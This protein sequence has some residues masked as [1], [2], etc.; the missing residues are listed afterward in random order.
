MCGDADAGVIEPPSGLERTDYV[1]S[2]RTISL[3]WQDNSSSETQFVVEKS[4]DGGA[5][6]ATF[7]TVGTGTT[8]FSGTLPTDDVFYYFRVKASDGVDSSAPSN[9]I[10]FT[11]TDP[12]TGDF[13]GDGMPDGF[14]LAHGL[15]PY[16]DDSYEDADGDRYPNIFEY[17][18][19]TDVDD[20]G[21]FPVADYIADGSVSPHDNV[22]STIQA[23]LN[24]VA[25]DHEII[26]VNPGSYSGSGNINL[27]VSGSFPVLLLSGSGAR[28]TSISGG[29]TARILTTSNDAVIDGFTFLDGAEE[30]GGAILAGGGHLLVI[31]CVFSGNHA[32]QNGGAIRQEGG[33]V[34]VLHSTFLENAAEMEGSALYV[35][36]GAAVVAK[37]ILWDSGTAA[38]IALSGSGASVE[39]SESVVHGGYTGTGNTSSDPLLRFDGHLFPLSP[40]IDSGGELIT[41]LFDM[42]G[43]LR[44]AGSTSDMGADEWVDTDSDSLPDWWEMAEF[45][46][47]GNNG[48]G[49]PDGDGLTN[50]QEYEGG[51]SPANY[52]SQ[53][54]EAITPTMQIVGGNNQFG[55]SGTF[56]ELQLVVLV[57]NGTTPLANAP[58]NYVVNGTNTGFVSQTNSG[59]NLYASQ[60][61]RTGSTGQTAMYFQFSPNDGTRTSVQATTNGTSVNFWEHAFT[62]PQSGLGLWLNANEGITKDGAGKVS[63]WADQSGNSRS[64][65]QATSGNQPQYAADVLNGNPAIRFNG[66]NQYM[67]I[68]NMDIASALPFTMFTVTKGATNPAYAFDSAPSQANVFRFN[69]SGK[70][71]FW[72]QNPAIPVTW[73]AAGSATMIL[74][75]KGTGNARNLSIFV[76]GS[77]QGSTQ[78]GGTAAVVFKSPQIGRVNTSG[79]Y[80]SGDIS[81]I[82]YYNRTL[83]D[84]ERSKTEAYLYWKFGLGIQPRVS[85]PSFAAPEALYSGT[86]N[87]ALSSDPGSTIYYT[88]DGSVPTASSTVYTGPIA[89]TQT[90]TIRAIASKAYYQNSSESSRTY[91][92]DNDTSQVPR[93]GLKMWLRAD[94]GIEMGSMREMTKWRDMSGNGAH[95]IQADP[96]ACPRLRTEVF[97]GKPVVNFDGTNSYMTFSSTLNDAD[98]LPLTLIVVARSGTNPGGLF[99]S[100]PTQANVFRFLSNKIEFWN[101]SPNVNVSFPLS[102][103]I[104]TVEGSKNGS[105]QRLLSVRVNGVVQDGGAKTGGTAGVVFMNG[106]LGRYNNPSITDHRY[107]GGDVAEILF[108]ERS[109]TSTERGNIESYLTSRYGI[110]GNSDTDGDSL[111]D[112]WETTYFGGISATPG[113]DADN[114]GLT[115]LEEFVLGTSPIDSDTDGDG[116]TDKFEGDFRLDPLDDDS[117]EDPDGDGLMNADE[118]AAGTNPGA[119]DSDGDGMPDR[120]EVDNGLNPWSDDSLDDFDGDRVPNLWECKKGTVASADTSAPLWDYIVDPA[121]AGDSASDNIVSSI[122]AAIDAAPALGAG[123]VGYSTVYVKS[124]VYTD[125]LNI[126][127][128]KVIAIF[129]ELGGDL[130][131][132]ASSD[133]TKSS[134]NFF[135]IGAVDGLLLTRPE[136]LTESGVNTS[137]GV[138]VSA[139]GKRAKISNCVITGQR[140]DYGAVRN[141]SGTLL[142]EHCTLVGNYRYGGGGSI[143]YAAAQQELDVSNSIFWNPNEAGTTEFATSGTVNANYNIIRGGQFGGIDQNPKLRS[144]WTLTALSPA[145]NAGGMSG[146]VQHD[147]HGEARPSGTARD[148]GVDEFVDE[149]EDGMPDHWEM[150]WFSDLAQDANDDFDGDGLK[151]YY[152]YL[153]NFN[154][155]EVDTNHNGVGDYY[156]AL[157]MTS[158]EVY[159][160][161]WASDSDGDGVNAGWEEYF[162]TDAALADTNGDGLSDLFVFAGVESLNLDVDGDGLTN[163]EELEA[164]TSPFVADTDH[165]GVADNLDW[166]PNDPSLSDAPEGDPMDTT[167]PVLTV[168]QPDGVV[169]TP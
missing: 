107:F 149:D 108:F 78:A 25:S 43:E 162:H 64:A 23:A 166:Y 120:Y 155:T 50:A 39:V 141:D 87:A 132:I 15:D 56:A 45:G 57:T 167:G 19:G 82:I 160:S 89:I 70:I 116:M 96:T 100:A 63:A 145:I 101:Q 103:A 126:P 111:P 118:F 95:V 139:P 99:D 33:E 29:G 47:L 137:P 150:E 8:T 152:E 94:L 165:D 69:P 159:P 146:G 80:F 76:N 98:S 32:V 163:A 117:E 168:I 143:A 16:R 37:S 135:G 36:A 106:Q 136:N 68:A 79:F 134:L 49:D 110:A 42:D 26:R 113:G 75:T 18:K 93:S 133:W 4:A 21:S 104:A 128:N 148:I 85:S 51:S 71:E 83:T 11:G 86:L 31:N 130:P 17:A 66:T 12:E 62:I 158:S 119:A 92:V 122:T 34:Q 169:L 124:V 44:P 84:A 40:A 20:E 6:W 48:A 164:G 121:H 3:G 97:N 153:L 14:E 53:G 114:D 91:F 88:T 151:D 125:W 154:P 10:S 27:T 46:S 38:E 72:D 115:N 65:S 138:Y 61:V 161:E 102:G 30:E 13:D 127:A 52:Y 2:P 60:L 9:V 35:Q 24:Q 81:E 22:Y 1:E 90:S 147:F 129:G 7:G 157:S 58:V 73:E 156:E 5:N 123:G 59:T 105:N 55:Q 144:D 131:R 109:L 41:S 54:G 67:S 140:S 112:A 74:G 142:I 28:S 77:Q